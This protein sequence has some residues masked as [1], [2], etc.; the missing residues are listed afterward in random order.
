MY[1]LVTY[2][3]LYHFLVAEFVRPSVYLSMLLPRYGRQIATRRGTSM[4][5]FIL[6]RVVPKGFLAECAYFSYRV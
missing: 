3:A 1:V 2:Y 6:Y 4:N 5:V